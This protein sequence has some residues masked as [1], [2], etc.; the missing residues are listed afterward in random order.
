MS[1]MSKLPASDDILVRGVESAELS[2]QADNRLLSDKF[3]LRIEAM[4]K[5]ANRCIQQF[6]GGRAGSRA[7]KC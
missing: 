1:A 2:G 3:G 4:Q 7:K 6:I 5:P